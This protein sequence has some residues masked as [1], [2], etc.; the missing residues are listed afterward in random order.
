[1]LGYFSSLRELGGTR[2]LIEDELTSRLTQYGKRRRLDEP[3][4]PFVDREI[5]YEVQE[6]TSRVR[7][8]PDRLGRKGRLESAVPRRWQASTWRSRRT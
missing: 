1:M 4:S 2:R 3:D 5:R 8:G 6:L 7:H